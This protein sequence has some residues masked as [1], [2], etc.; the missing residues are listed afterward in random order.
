MFAEVVSDAKLVRFVQSKLGLR[1]LR[2]VRE[3]VSQFQRPMAGEFLTPSCWLIAAA[4]QRQRLGPRAI[5]SE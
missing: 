5:G 3:K 4:C 2:S 1:V